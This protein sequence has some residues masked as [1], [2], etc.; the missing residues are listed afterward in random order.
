MKIDLSLLLICFR[1]MTNL[2]ICVLSKFAM[3][4]AKKIGNLTLYL[5]MWQIDGFFILWEQATR[6]TTS[7]CNMGLDPG[8]LLHMKV[9]EHSI[10]IKLFT[11]KI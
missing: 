4:S 8:Q 2:N 10:K 11:R 1:F 9:A 5:N 6:I 3:L 7:L